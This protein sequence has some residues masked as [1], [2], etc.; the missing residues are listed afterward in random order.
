MKSLIKMAR[1][2]KAGFLNNKILSLV[3]GFTILNLWMN[4]VFAVDP[5][6]DILSAS[7]ADITSNF[8]QSSTIMYGVYMA[9]IFAGVAAYI[10]TKNLFSLLGLVIVVIFTSVGFSLI[11]T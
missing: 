4:S 7:K 11:G 1:K 3:I 10:K 9:E 5:S 6:S 2:I 8:G